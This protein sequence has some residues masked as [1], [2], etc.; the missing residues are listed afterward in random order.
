MGVLKFDGIDDELIWSTLASP[1]ANVTDGAWTVAAVV[2]RNAVGSPA[3]SISTLL[4]ASGASSEASLAFD[5]AN[6]VIADISGVSDPTSPTAFSSTANVYMFALSKAAGTATLRL[7]WKVGSGGA[8][9]HENLT[10]TL[11]DQI[12]STSI[13]VGGWAPFNGWIG[14]VAW[15]EGAMSDTN[16]EALDNNWRTSDLWN[17]AHGQPVFLAQCNVSGASVVDLAS[18]ATS[19]SATGTTL[20]AAETLNGWTFDGATL[21]TPPYGIL[22]TKISAGVSAPTIAAIMQLVEDSGA[23]WVRVALPWYDVQ[24][25]SSSSFTWT[26]YDIVVSE[27]TARGLKLIGQPFGTPSWARG[28]LGTVFTPPD[29]G[30]GMP[31]WSAFMTAFASR[32]AGQIAIYEIWNEPDHPSF[33]PGTDP[34]YAELL[35]RAA[36]SVRAADATATVAVGGLANGGSY[37]PNFFTSIL[38][39]GTNP[40]GLNTDFLND[41]MN[42]FTMAAMSSLIATRRSQLATR[43]IPAKPI[44]VT[45]IDYPSDP[46]FQT[47]TGYVGGG[48]ATQAAYL[49]DA[50]TNLIA[51]PN[52]ANVI[53]W[54]QLQDHAGEYVGFYETV[55][56]VLENGTAKQAYAQFQTE[57]ILAPAA[58]H[59]LILR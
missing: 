46:T 12:D 19:F 4:S 8:W 26:V 2:R 42:G 9:T 25:T 54:A 34:E 50:F 59:G 37:D 32:Y 45:E 58:P 53:I 38:D 43:G 16:K 1:L 35:K 47:V 15:W 11:V 39:D 24:P 23:S 31:G 7:G 28:G 48:E 27:I 44:L 52:R 20:D 40:A 51:A 56:L 3:V 41:H 17:S 30:T 55:G 57:S 5:A 22:A 18:N 36:D 49:H 29:A 14:V 21:V 10:T 6:K 13:R 33:W